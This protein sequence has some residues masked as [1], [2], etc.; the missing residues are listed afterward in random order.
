VPIEDVAGAVKDLIQEGKVSTSDYLKRGT[1]HPPGTRNSASDGAFKVNTP[2]WW[3]RP[4]EEIIPTLEELASALFRS[5]RLARDS[6]LGRLPKHTVLTKRTI[7]AVS[8]RFSPEAR[9]ANRAL[10]D[11]IATF[12]SKKNA[13]PLRSRS[14]GSLQRNPG[15]FRFPAPRNWSDLTR[16]SERLPSS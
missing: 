10:V 3:K 7:V 4:E 8:P 2:L 1:D 5:V 16:T 13:H 14:P 11:L 15:S 12:A 6:S 9:K